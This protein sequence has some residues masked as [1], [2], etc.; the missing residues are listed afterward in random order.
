MRYCKHGVFRK[1]MA[2]SVRGTTTWCGSQ[3]KGI[4][5]MSDGTIGSFRKRRGQVLARRI[6]WPC[7][8]LSRAIRIVDVGGIRDYWECVGFDGIAE[9]TLLNID[10]ADPGR[11]TTQ[12]VLFTDMVGDARS[13]IGI[14]DLAFDFMAPSRSYNMWVGGMTCRKWKWKQGGLPD[15][16]GFRRRPGSFPLNP[17]SVFSSG[18]GLQRRLLPVCCLSQRDIGTR[19]GRAAECTPNELTV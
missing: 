2:I 13:L 3:S 14:D 17:V 19:I 12:A 18:I 7:Q 11:K 10:P 16:A 6:L 1:L 15:M 9:I 8:K 5:S 4:T